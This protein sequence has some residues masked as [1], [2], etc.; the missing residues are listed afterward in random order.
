MTGQ[1]LKEQEAPDSQNLFEALT[2]QDPVGRDDMVLEGMQY[3]KVY[4]DQQYAYIPPHDD[5]FICQ[6]TG[7]EKGN[8]PEP[9]LFDLHDDVGQVKNL[10][11]EMPEKVDELAAKL[12]SIVSKKK[13]R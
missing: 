10:A 2:G 8:T 9:Q 12:E 3:K 7:N 1:P 6:Y 5:D 11:T 13:S 4:R